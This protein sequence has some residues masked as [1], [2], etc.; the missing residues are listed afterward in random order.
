M[1][2]VPGPGELA[3]LVVE[4]AEPRVVGRALVVR[5]GPTV[6]SRDPAAPV[7]ST[8]ARPDPPVAGAAVPPAGWA[9]LRWLVPW[10]DLVGLE[11][12]ASTGLQGLGQRV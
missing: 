9:V 5:P 4:L 8:V 10:H 12:Q 1:V 3:E 6:A 7:V 11:Q 2:E